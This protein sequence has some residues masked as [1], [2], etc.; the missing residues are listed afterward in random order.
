M[1]VV[2]GCD[3]SADG[4]VGLGGTW[5]LLVGLY[6]LLEDGVAIGWVGISVVVGV[7]GVDDLGDEAEVLFELFWGE[8]LLGLGGGGEEEEEG[9]Q[10]QLHWW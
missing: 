5:I 2:R 3:H 4:V 9:K 1:D 6:F 7:Q 8:W 10:V